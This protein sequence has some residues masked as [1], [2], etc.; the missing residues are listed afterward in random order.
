MDKIKSN[1]LFALKKKKFYL[2]TTKKIILDFQMI[3]KKKQFMFYT[4]V[5][6][7][8]YSALVWVLFV[9]LLLHSRLSAFLKVFQ[10]S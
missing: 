8:F 10:P 7:L 4:E 6:I 3:L 5:E 2:G 9:C 1:I